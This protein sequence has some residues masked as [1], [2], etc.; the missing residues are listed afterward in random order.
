MTNRF[1]TK[2]AAR[3][4][5]MIGRAH[6]IV[7]VSHDLTN[8]PLICERGLWLDRGRVQ[9]DGRIAEVVTAY[10]AWSATPTAQALAI[11]S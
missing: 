4:R 2:A 10:P 11:A 8:M 6:L 5:E 1:Q 3:M 9:L 7:L